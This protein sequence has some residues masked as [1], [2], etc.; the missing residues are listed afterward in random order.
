MTKPIFIT[1][2]A[3]LGS[4]CFSVTQTA[5]N[6]RVPVML[7][8]VTCVGCSPRPAPPAAVGAPTVQDATSV[9][10]YLIETL[11][12]TTTGW[13]SIPSR[14]DLKLYEAR[15]PCHQEVVLRDVEASSW[16]MNF[17]LFG[18]Y[19]KSSVEV[20]GDQVRVP[21]GSCD[22]YLERWPLVGP[23]GIHW[24]LPPP[25]PPPA[26][27]QPAVAPPAPPAPAVPGNGGQP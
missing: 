9:W 24:P 21:A 12:T 11:Y 18:Y 2:V 23:L 14:L 8:P 10:S 25:P 3:V 19:A 4:G 22:P 6:A 17:V 15:D 26:W 27:Q 1:V 20:T 7:G 13:G 5:H 16:A